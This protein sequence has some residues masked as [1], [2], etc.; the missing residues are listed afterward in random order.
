MNWPN[1]QTIVDAATAALI[2]YATWLL[3]PL[4]QLVVG[5]ARATD[6]PR[7]SPTLSRAKMRARV[8]QRLEMLQ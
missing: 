8:R 2:V 3:W 5:S 6:R 4:G 1:M 7:R